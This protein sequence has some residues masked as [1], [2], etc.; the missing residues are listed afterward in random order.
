MATIMH[1]GITYRRGHRRRRVGTKLRGAWTRG[2]SHVVARTDHDWSVIL[3]I[4]HLSPH[5]RWDI[6]LGPI[7]TNNDSMS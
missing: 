4:A 3:H 1:Y 2:V 5:H 7:R 6:A